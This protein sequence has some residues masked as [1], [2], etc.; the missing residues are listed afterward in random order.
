MPSLKNTDLQSTENFI[1]ELNNTMNVVQSG[2]AKKSKKASKKGSKKSSKKS[3]KK[4]SKKASKKSSK[5]ARMIDIEHA[6]WGGKKGSKKSSKK[7]S[8]KASKKSSKK[9]SKKASKKGSKKGSKMSRMIDAT[10][11]PAEG[12]VV[13]GGAKK[14][15]KK[16]SKKASKKS[17]KKSSKK[18]SKQK[19]ELPEALKIMH[20][21]N[22]K[23]GDLTGHKF[24]KQLLK[25]IKHHRDS[26]KK[27]VKN[28]ENKQDV[29]NKTVELV[30]EEV[31]KMG[32]EKVTKKID[33]M[34]L[35]L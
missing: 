28:I 2:G 21:T 35:I 16:G 19:R 7:G 22:K 13:F 3:S 27:E 29:E 18:G 34:G 12:L 14:S 10:V 17:S 4:G 6:Q 26:A 1:N 32:K 33:E 24:G 5:M 20:A 9:S 30:K 11:N 25:Y 8:K 31:S 15:S 23:V